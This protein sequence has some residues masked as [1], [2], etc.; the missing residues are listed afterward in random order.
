MHTLLNLCE[1]LSLPSAHGLRPEY[2]ED[3]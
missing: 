3:L 2:F 1:I